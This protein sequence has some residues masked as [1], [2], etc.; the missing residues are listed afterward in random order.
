MRGSCGPRA[1]GSGRGQSVRWRRRLITLHRDVGYLCVGLTLVYSISGIA[2]NHR[3]HW[4]Y[5]YS[6]EHRTDRVGGPATLLNLPQASSTAG[7]LARLHTKQLVAALVARTGRDA[8]PH[9]AFWRGPDRL[10]LFFGKG[11]QDVVDYVP[12]TGVVEHWV[13]NP[14]PLIRQVNFLHLNEPRLVWTWAADIYALGLIF[15]GLS[16]IFLVKGRHG[17]G[18]R[19]GFLVALGLLIPLA[20]VFLLM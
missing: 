4:N 12:S 16:G 9:N 8:L 20:A 5:N 2:V 7:Q 11:A 3:H 17:L 1:P 14:R 19:G 18:G 10:S 6:V 13:R 15:L